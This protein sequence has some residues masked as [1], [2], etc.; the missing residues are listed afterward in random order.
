MMEMLNL[1]L[2]R[3]PAGE[4]TALG[5]GFT[6]GVDPLFSFGA[7]TKSNPQFP[8]RPAIGGMGAWDVLLSF[9]GGPPGVYSP[10]P[11][12]APTFGLW[13]VF[14][15]NGAIAINP[16]GPLP[17]AQWQPGALQALQISDLGASRVR[18]PGALETQQ[19]ATGGIV[20]PFARSAEASVSRDIAAS[21]ALMT[22]FDLANLMQG[23]TPSAPPS[24]AAARQRNQSLYGPPVSGA[25]ATAPGNA[26]AGPV[27]GGA[28]WTGV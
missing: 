14:A 22:M 11:L 7:Y 16:T 18:I 25:A 20:T 8:G 2:P 13:P 28:S 27:A 15:G 9:L 17:S 21:D 3:G 24:E 4:Q 26:L 5:Q 12:V 23:F 1:S 6:S 10:G 19:A